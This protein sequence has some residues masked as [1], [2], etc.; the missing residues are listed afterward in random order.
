[1]IQVLLTSSPSLD[2][3]LSSYKYLILM[4][5][6]VKWFNSSSCWSNMPV[7]LYGNGARSGNVSWYAVGAINNNGNKKDIPLSVDSMT[8]LPTSE[9]IKPFISLC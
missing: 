5:V 8:H 3:I 2:C 6:L 1:M 7:A 9:S 4:F